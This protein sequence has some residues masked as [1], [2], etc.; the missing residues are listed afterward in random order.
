MLE[1]AVNPCYRLPS[2]ATKAERTAAHRARM[3]RKLAS[4]GPIHAARQAHWSTRT[5]AKQLR[6]LI[7]AN[8]SAG[9][10]DYGMTHAEHARRKGRG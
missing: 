1:I 6:W 9:H 7:R 3:R 2:T 8:L 4:R 5:G 10:P